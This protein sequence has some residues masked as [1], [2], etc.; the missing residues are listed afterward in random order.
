MVKVL[1]KIRVVLIGAGSR[2]F[3]RGA[4]ADLLSSKELR[5]TNLT[6]SLVDI[7][8]SAL[9]RMFR[10]A[11]QLKEYR[12]SNAEIEATTDRCE[13]LKGA[14]HVITAVAI[15]RA[16]L[17]ERDFYTP[18]SFGFKHVEGETAGPGAAFHTLRSLN[19]MIP[20]ARDMEKICPEALL[21]N[22]TNP[23]SRVCLGVNMLTNI[24]VVGLC[25]GAFATLNKVAQILGRRREQIDIIIAGINHFHW[26]LE[27]HDKTTGE[28][29]HPEFHRGI[30]K[31][32]VEVEPLAKIMYETFGLLPFPVDN[33]IGEY[34]QF[35][36]DVTGPL[37]RWG[38]GDLSYKPRP[39]EREKS[40]EYLK[41]TYG[42]VILEE[43]PP[44][45]RVQRVAEG[46]EPM[47]EQLAHPSGEL[48]VPIIC[49]IEFDRKRQELSVNIPND[50]YAISNLPEDAIVE[51]PAVVDA[52]G[53]HPVKVGPLPEPIAAMC[54]KQISIQKLLVEAYAQRSKKLLLQAIAIDPTVESI[55]RAKRLIDLMLRIQSDFIPEFQ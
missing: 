30:K 34:V 53:I 43:H 52:N 9:D 27:I 18:L 44:V 48:G 47:T 45:E 16:E 54:R 40:I 2:S 26:V 10:F 21:I 55:P 37:Y 36:Y 33:H 49:D 19:L 1:K 8:E 6:I 32:N 20:I 38:S 7:D 25:H 35:A 14:N 4:I 12:N 46:K 5:D 15:R 23:E 13:A 22:Y 42:D 31:S 39:E 24:R 50:D 11:Q 29:L 17:W 3:G 41:S 28:D 51:I